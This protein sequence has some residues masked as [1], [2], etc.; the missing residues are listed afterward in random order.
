MRTRQFHTGPLCGVTTFAARPGRGFLH[1]LRA[2]A[3]E[4]SHQLPGGGRASLRIEEP[5]LL[6][7]PRPLEHAF[8]NAPSDGSDFACATLDFDGGPDHPL[9]RTLPPVLAVPLSQ[10][11]TLG[12]ALD[13]LYAEV[14]GARCGGRVLT[15]RLFE[16]VLI[17][18]FRWLLDHPAEVGLPDGL[19]TGL[20]DGRLA[21]V[22]VAIHEDPGAD[23]D[24]PAMAR[25]AHLS[26]SSFAARFRAHVGQS[27]ADYLAGWRMVV[28]REQ[29]RGGTSV[30][31]TAVELGYASPAAFTRAFTK[32]VGCS[33]R[34]WLAEQRDPST[35]PDR[36]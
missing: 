14:D 26:R 32:R 30:A 10:V 16:V 15:D 18:L 9:V 4:V 36:R 22:L 21:P 7:Y 6:L 29:L 20:S 24:L 11:E 27:P 1:I 8:H 2:G 13:L 31:R 3:M 17:Q 23:W 28:A 33:P 19:I 25:V 12:P 34:A 5:S 35:T